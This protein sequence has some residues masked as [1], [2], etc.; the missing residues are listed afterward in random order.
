MTGKSDHSWYGDFVHA[1]KGWYQ[2]PTTAG[3]MGAHVREIKK[4]NQAGPKAQPLVQQNK[5]KFAQPEQQSGGNTMGVG[6][7]VRPPHWLESIAFGIGIVLTIAVSAVGTWYGFFRVHDIAAMELWKRI[8][9]ALFFGG[10]AG[11]LT[12][13]FLCWIVGFVVDVLLPLLIRV[14]IVAMAIGA[15]YL[16]ANIFG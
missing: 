3:M 7:A 6:G 14:A 9:A 8:P 12:W 1:E 2:A 16:G 4:Q 10:F 11:C 5:T 13:G 15:L